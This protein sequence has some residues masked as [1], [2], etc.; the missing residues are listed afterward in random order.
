MAVKWNPLNLSLKPKKKNPPNVAEQ[1]FEEWIATKNSR[2][3]LENFLKSAPMPI[4]SPELSEKECEQYI[5]QVGQAVKH[6][7]LLWKNKFLKFGK[8]YYKQNK[9]IDIWDK[10]EPVTVDHNFSILVPV[11]RKIIKYALYPVYSKYYYVGN[12]NDSNNRLKQKKI[13]NEPRRESFQIQLKGFRKT[14]MNRLITYDEKKYEKLAEVNEEKTFVPRA[15]A[16]T[17]DKM[18]EKPH[19]IQQYF[20]YCSL[21]FNINEIKYLC[22]SFPSEKYKASSSSSDDLFQNASFNILQFLSFIDYL[23]QNYYDNHKKRYHQLHEHENQSDDNM[24]TLSPKNSP[25]NNKTKKKKKECICKNYSGRYYWNLYDAIGISTSK[26]VENIISRGGIDNDVSLGAVGVTQG[27]NVTF[28]LKNA[29]IRGNGEIIRYKKEKYNE[30]ENVES[31]RIKYL[32]QEYDVKKTNS[33]NYNDPAMQYYPGWNWKQK[34]EQAVLKLNIIMKRFASAIVEK[35]LIEKL[36]DRSLPKKPVL[37]RYLIAFDEFDNLI[38]QRNDSND[39][40][41]E[42]P[43][44][45]DENKNDSIINTSLYE[46]NDISYDN[47]NILCLRWNVDKNVTYYKLEQKKAHGYYTIH[48]DPPIEK[49]PNTRPQGTFKVINL[50]PNTSYVSVLFIYIHTHTYTQTPCQLSNK[51]NFT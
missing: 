16:A 46:N 29:F 13:F 31:P 40:I 30:E 5:R 24:L 12:N 8:G 41:V 39:K 19:I 49:V 15:T 18:L 27:A 50:K 51:I 2:E 38:Q 1:A 10:L 36:R 7:N 14:L 22:L 33:T 32:T 42:N 6:I 4:N 48:V 43:E 44:E 37:K 11:L 47:S 9:L 23:Q 17:V 21:R 25:R 35:N 28:T 26:I 45:G 3:K 34:R 20:E